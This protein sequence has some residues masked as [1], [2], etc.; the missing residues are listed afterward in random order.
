MSSLTVS[1]GIAIDRAISCPG[2]GKD[3]VDGVNGRTKTELTCASA[4]QLKT[5]AEVDDESAVDTKKFAAAVME[6]S[7]GCSPALECKRLLEFEDH[8]HMYCSPE[9]GLGKIDSLQLYCLQQSDEE[10]MD[11][12][13]P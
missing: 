3:I 6:G 12:Q 4:N 11:S 9:L 2:H 1:H 7:N 10:E 5:A 13:H 8:Y